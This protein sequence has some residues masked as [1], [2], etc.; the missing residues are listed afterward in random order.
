MGIPRGSVGEE[1][2]CDAG[3]SG[4]IPVQG[5]SPGEGHGDLREYSCLGN[6]MDRGARRATVHGVT[7]VGRDLVAKPPP[8]EPWRGRGERAASLR[9][10]ALLDFS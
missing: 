2:A 10:L 7:S 9:L 3:D 8:P 5:G 1:S 6:S 4:L